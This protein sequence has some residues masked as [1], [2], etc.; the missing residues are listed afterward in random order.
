VTGTSFSVLVIGGYGVFGSRICQLLAAEGGFRVL[1]AGRSAAKAERLARELCRGSPQAQVEG[2][3]VD[4]AV[5]IDRTLR[6]TG[7]DLV[8]HA[9]GPFQGQDYGVAR[10]CIAQGVHYVD[11]S[12]GRDFV[13]GIAALDREAQQAGVAVVSGA[14]SVPGLSGAVVDHLAQGLVELTSIAVGITPG[15]RIP[16]GP[17]L[18]AAILGYAGQPIQ[19]WSGGRWVQ[20]YGWQDLSRRTLHL[21]DAKP[22]GPRWF[23]ACEVPDLALF[24]RRYDGV[25]SVA[26]H[27]GLELKALHFGLWALSW[28]VRWGLLRSLV[29]ITPLAQAFASLFKDFGSERGGMF[30]E[31]TGKDAAGRN[32]RRRWTLIAESGHGPFIPCLPS[33]VLSKALAEGRLRSRGAWP[34][35]GLFDLEDFSRAAE[36]F[37]IRWGQEDSLV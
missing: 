14:S 12:D 8:I 4:I 9:A 16:R 11:L 18:V 35:L 33:V 1:V 28:P 32:R 31:V 26:F 6:S 3:G 30:V 22:V 20:A 27:A 23:A 10:T 19:R 37:D 21:P 2:L 13:C 7:T 25:Q 34:C 17:G 36:K 5:G 29:P 15:N 24:P